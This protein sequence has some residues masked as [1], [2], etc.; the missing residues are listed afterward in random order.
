MLHDP[1]PLLGRDDD[2]AAVTALLR[3]V[4]GHLDRRPR[5]AGQ[6]P[7]G[8]RGG[9][10]GRATVVHF[11]PLAGVTEDVDVADEVASVLGVGESRRVPVAHQAGPSDAVTGIVAALGPGPALLVLDN[12]EHVIGRSGRSWYRL[13]WPPPGT[14]GY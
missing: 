10:P 11:V 7:A 9:P 6:D 3:T 13:W 2:I 14:C 8:A 12:C 5:R 4:P 1:N